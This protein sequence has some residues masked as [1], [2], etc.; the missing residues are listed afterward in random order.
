[1]R[2]QGGGLTGTTRSWGGRKILIC[3]DAEVDASHYIDPIGK[4]VFGFDHVKQ[5]RCGAARL[6]FRWR[7][8]CDARRRLFLQELIPEDLVDLPKS[9]FESERCVRALFCRAG[10]SR[11]D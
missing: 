2:T 10:S 7:R 9:D 8:C 3:E 6:G 1:M 11:D 5:V 4:R